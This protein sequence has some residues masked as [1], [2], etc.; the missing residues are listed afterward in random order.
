MLVQGAE[1][2][3]RDHGESIAPA[4]A[5]DKIHPFSRELGAFGEERAYTSVRYQSPQSEGDRPYGAGRGFDEHTQIRSTL[6]G[7]LG[8]ALALAS[9]SALAISFRITDLGTLG[10]TLVMALPSTPR[11]R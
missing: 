3:E 8:V 10:G 9:G 2:V 11:G 1:G 6:I 4:R 5:C 7:T